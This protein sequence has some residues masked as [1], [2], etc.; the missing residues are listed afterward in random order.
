MSSDDI[1][2]SSIR[3][4]RTVVMGF[5]ARISV[6]RLLSVQ[7]AAVLDAADGVEELTKIQVPQAL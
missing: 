5:A 6:R 1:S 4:V 2:L 3:S 7:S